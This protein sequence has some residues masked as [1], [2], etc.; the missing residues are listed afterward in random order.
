MMAALACFNHCL[1]SYFRSASA[2]FPHF[3]IGRNNLEKFQLMD[4][5]VS[6]IPID[7]LIDQP[8]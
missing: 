1:A 8:F 6:S 7:K 2:T 5:L 3:N 4:H